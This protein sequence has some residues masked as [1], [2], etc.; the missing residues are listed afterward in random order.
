MGEALAPFHIQ[1]EPHIQKGWAKI[2]MDIFTCL[3]AE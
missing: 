3:A 2:L 1:R